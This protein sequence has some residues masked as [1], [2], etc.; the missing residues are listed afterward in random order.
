MNPTLLLRLTPGDAHEAQWAQLD[1]DALVEQ[2]GRDALP[3]LGANAQG[4]DIVVLVPTE[5]VLLT[6]VSIPTHNRQR[7]LQAI[8]YALE[9]QL[10]SDIDDLHFVPGQRMADGTC[11]VAVVE[12]A[13]MEAWLD[14]LDAAGLQPKRMLPDA[15]AVPL[16]D[17][18]WAGVVDGE[19][20]LIRTG[21][22][23]GFAGETV[24]LAVLLDAALADAETQPPQR[25]V[26]NGDTLDAATV[27]DVLAL[28]Q[29][30]RP[31]DAVLAEG[32]AGGG[33]LE[34]RTGRHVGRHEQRARWRPWIPAAALLVA[35]VLV[36]A[37]RVVVERWQL[38]RE[39]A[40]L[41]ARVETIFRDVFPDATRVAA[42]RERMQ[43]HLNRLRAGE[44]PADGDILDTLL[45]V[46]PHLRENH[47][48]LGG[49]SWRSD[50]LELELTART[51]QELDALQQTL[52]GEDTLNVEIRQARSQ[53]DEVQGR[54]LIRREA[55]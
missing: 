43:T 3:A 26:L 37:S 5:E 24:N 27:E 47:F 21:P 53:D 41:D 35:F 23:T 18:A 33:G 31:A 32:I 52:D 38:Q 16:Q 1:R 10:A 44:R 4:R 9:D 14:A 29:Q 22:S 8:P 13:R 36:D 30:Q 42:P 17:D 6:R 7:L 40:S 45:V 20:F 46:G 49:L 28:E 15:L 55:S 34:L 2:R 48:R 51:L 25:L 12:H 50:T 39:L 19:R 54:L 11:P